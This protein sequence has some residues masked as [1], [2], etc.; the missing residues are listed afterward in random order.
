MLVRALT[1][2][3]FGTRRRAGTVFDI[4][5]GTKLGRWMEKVKGVKAPLAE[6]KADATPSSWSEANRKVADAEKAQLKAK[7]ISGGDLA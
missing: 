7:T 3:F 4:P 6:P 5:D 1:D 2:G